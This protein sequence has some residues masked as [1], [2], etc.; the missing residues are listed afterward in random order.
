VKPIVNGLWIG[1]PNLGSLELLTLASFAKQGAEFHLWTYEDLCTQ[2]P[3]GVIV[4]DGNEILPAN[5]I[6]KYPERMLLDFGG[7][8]YVGF[9]EIFRY[10]VLYDCGGWWSDMDVTCLKPLS[11]I[12]EDYFFRTHGVLALVGNIMK[13]PRHSELM[14]LCYEKAKI[15]V[16]ENTIDWHHAIRI[17]GYYVEHLGLSKWIKNEFCNLDFMECVNNFI[18]I[19]YEIDAIPEN[20]F[21]IHWMNSVVNKQYCS[22]SV[23]ERLLISHNCPLRRTFI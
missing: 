18:R 2:V 16:N 13:V 23:L 20:W 4:R 12:T 19:P 17:L 14:R 5:T 15:E 6:F 22:G 3:D 7:G 10:K 11:L 8:S 1:N 9:S 21:F